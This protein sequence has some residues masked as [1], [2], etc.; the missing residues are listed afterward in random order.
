M[1]QLKPFVQVLDKGLNLQT[2]KLIA[3]PGSVLNSMNYEQV[4]FQGQKRID[5]FTRYDGSPLSA[6]D[7]VYLVPSGNGEDHYP[8]VVVYNEG[9]PYGVMASEQVLDGGVIPVAVFD[10][11]ALPDDGVWASES[12]MATEDHTSLLIDCNA[13]LRSLVE[14]LPGAVSGLHWFRDRLY[15]VSD[16]QD[17][18]PPDP[19]IDTAGKASLFES[20]S[21]DQV[22]DAGDGDF[23]WRFVHQGWIIPFINGKSSFGSFPAVNQNL[24]GVGVQG[25]T[26]IDGTHGSPEGVTQGNAITGLPA[27][28]SGWKSSHIPDSYTL[29][30]DN[31]KLEDDL[32][33]YADAFFSWA[34]GAVTSPGPNDT[35]VQYSPTATVEVDV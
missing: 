8:Y 31:I 13:Y 10:F 35:L 26:S 27:Q 34:D 12:G 23:G 11:T 14:S 2:A 20:R 6:L 28:V 22:L 24:K 16:I 21:V 5:G 3:P 15:A 19:R 1:S 25:P 4:D 18:A 29:V 32:S 30:A 7:D 9:V 33:I 17:Y